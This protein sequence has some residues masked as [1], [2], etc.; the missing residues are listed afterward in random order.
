MIAKIA[1]SAAVFAIDKPYSYRV[2]PEQ[3]V[4]A[5]MRVIV[6]FGRGNRRSEGIV[7]DVCDEFEENLKQIERV[8]DEAPVL[9]ERQ[10]RVAAFI[11]ERY[12]CTFYE[13]A[14]AIL[15]AGLWFQATQTY[16]IV[17]DAGDW[18]VIAAR[19]ETAL[20]VMQSLEDMGGCT[21]ERALRAQFSDEET[22]QNALRY[23]LAKKLITQ[24]LDMAQRVGS[25]TERIASVCVSA[26]EAMAYA[27]TKQ[28]SAPLQKAVLE[29]LCT[30][31]SGSC[32]EIS[33]LTGAS[34]ATLR[35]LEKLGMI[36]ITEREV[37]RMP[38]MQAVAPAGEV[39]LT[40]EQQTAF[41]T[42]CGSMNSEKPGVA[43]LYGVTGSGK[44]AVYIRLIKEALA[45]GK[46]AILLVPEIALTPQLLGKLRS[47]F[48]DLVAVL[49]SSLLVTERYD[50]WRKI[51]EGKASVV[52]GTRSAVF[53]PVENLGILILDE[54]QEHT[55]KSEN[56]PRYHARE[57][58]IFRGAQENCLVL[59][60]SATPSIESMYRAKTGIYT[61]C[62]LQNRYNGRV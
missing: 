41:D 13:A 7:L 4:M 53:A 50:T 61:L 19:N 11:R 36:E 43:L 44:T 6:P 17:R 5:G 23:L 48:G 45:N 62:T 22:L 51:K 16:E 31:E 38:P 15:P 52:V 58:A 28:K 57:V 1:V 3:N 47:H 54:E 46:G 10:L 2:A 24:G 37:L 56:A 20:A 14:R 18:H 9:T 39:V 21:D 59:L 29:L 34:M 35:R 55:Y 27:M 49:H 32:R 40:E 25:K 33:Y 12:F 8:L 30:V 42:L 60:G 26:D